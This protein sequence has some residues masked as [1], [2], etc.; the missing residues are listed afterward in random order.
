[1]KIG[2]VSAP[3][4]PAPSPSSLTRV[5]VYGTL[6][7]GESNHALLATARFIAADRTAPTF[8]LHDLGSFPG[9]VASGAHSILGEVYDVDAPTL[10]ALDHLED[11]PRFYRR[12]ELELAGGLTAWTYLLTSEQV[13]GCAVIGSGDWRGY[14]KE[15]S[16]QRAGEE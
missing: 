13:V 1:M 10:V 15:Q 9:L 5:F 12:A 16:G 3:T 2:N 4:P 8:T 11:H 14:W 6:L 7:A